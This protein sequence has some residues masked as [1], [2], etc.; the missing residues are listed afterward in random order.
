L[1]ESF[2][3]KISSEHQLRIQ[4][5]IDEEEKMFG[6][7]PINKQNDQ[8]SEIYTNLKNKLEKLSHE[9]FW[10]HFRYLVQAINY[11]MT[12]SDSFSPSTKSSTKEKRG[13]TQ[14]RFPS[15]TD[16]YQRDGD[17]RMQSLTSPYQKTPL[18]FQ[19]YVN[20]GMEAF[21]LLVSLV[22]SGKSNSNPYK[23]A[24]FLLANPYHEISKIFEQRWELLGLQINS[25]FL[26]EEF[27]TV[28]ELV[29]EEIKEELPDAVLL[30]PIANSM[31]LEI[32][33]VWEIVR[34]LIANESFGK[35]QMQNGKIL[36]ILIDTTSV[37]S[38]IQIPADISKNTPQFMKI[39]FFESALKYKQCGLDIFGLGIIDTNCKTTHQ[40]ISKIRKQ[41]GTYLSPSTVNHIRFFHYISNPAKIKIHSQ[42]ANLL[43]ARLNEI[44]S[45]LIKKIHHPSLNSHPSHKN[46]NPQQEITGSL[47][48]IEVE[49][50]GRVNKPEIA[51][52]I[53][54]EAIKIAREMK[55]PLDQGTSFGFNTSRIQESID[56]IRIAVG[57][58][59]ADEIILL[60]AI[61]RKAIENLEKELRITSRQSQEKLN[62]EAHNH[63]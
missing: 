22:E 15:F 12:M 33:N 4:T 57:T 51:D 60:A 26:T 63:Q 16:D 34:K 3:K 44:K 48:N 40:R 24:S 39:V 59:S 17:L 18:Q 37:A 46:I 54:N 58:E 10:L 19:T 20:S 56:H 5:K 30:N 43:A 36:Y 50:F 25:E 9:E 7:S 28:E 13:L 23:K 27:M 8:V 11:L 53:T 32:T 52:F 1:T 41:K 14:T 6:F 29:T 2:C 35:S 45:P 62:H 38:Q 47:L 21:D 61:F 55:L 42:N 31:K 49:S